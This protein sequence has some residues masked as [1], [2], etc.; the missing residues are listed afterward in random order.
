VLI[1]AIVLVTDSMLRTVL[2]LPFVL[3][4]P[5]FTLRK[6]VIKMDL[7]RGEKRLKV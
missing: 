7:E 6:S 2:G 1:L 5:T 3:F 4:F